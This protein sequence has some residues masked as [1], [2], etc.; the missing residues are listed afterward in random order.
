MATKIAMVFR[1]DIF[2]SIPLA[3]KLANSHGTPGLSSQNVSAFVELGL[4]DRPQLGLNS[5]ITAS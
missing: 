5:D 3:T 1:L 2:S 4:S